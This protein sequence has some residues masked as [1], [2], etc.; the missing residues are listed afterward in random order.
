[1]SERVQNER[2]FLTFLLNTNKKQQKLLFQNLSKSQMAVIIEIVYNALLGNLTISD[3]DKNMLHR[4]RNV[5]RKIVSK[6]LS[7]SKRKSLLVK[8][9]KQI[10]LLMKHCEV[11][12][13][14]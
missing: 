4:Y 5:I 13:K 8:Y 1:M 9:F 6:Q 11:W 3:E 14:N 10:I 2:H 12:L 7:G